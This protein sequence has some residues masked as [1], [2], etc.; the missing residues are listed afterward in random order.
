MLAS[1]VLSVVLLCLFSSLFSGL[2]A[3]QV[4]DPW[5]DWLSAD[6]AHFRVHYRTEHRAQAERATRAAERAYPRITEALKWAPRGRTEIVLFNEYDLPNGYATPLPYNVI[7]VFLAPADDGQLLDNSNWMDLLLTHEFTHTVH[8]DKVRGAP[9][10]LQTIF[11]RVPWFF[12]NVFQPAWALEGLAVYNESDPATGRGRLR[13]P[14]FEALLRAQAPRGFPSL[15]ELNADGRSLPVSKVYLYGAYFYDFLGRRYGPDAIF[16]YVEQYSGN[17]VPRLH[18]NPYDI[19]GKTLDLLWDE[20]LVDLN[21]RVAERSEA[22]R[23]QPEAA[24]Q[25]LVGPLFDIG[26]VAPLG[27]GAALAV[28]DDGLGATQLVRVNADGSQKVVAHVH[29]GTHIDVAPNGRVLLAQADVCN[30]RYL[31]YDLYRLEADN[32]IQQLTTCARLRRAVQAGD[33]IA[34]LQHDAG[35]TRLLLLDSAGREQR[36]LLPAVEDTDLIDVAASPDGKRISVVSKRE[37][38]WQVREIDLERPDAPAR[39]LFTHNAPVHGLRHGP[40]GLEFIAVSDGVYNVWRLDGAT[41]VR[42]THSH[43]GVVAQSGTQADGSLMLSVIAADGYEL[44]RM[45]GATTLQRVAVRATTAAATPTRTSAAEPSSAAAT[46]GANA[47]GLSEGKTYSALSALYP[48]SWLPAITSDRGL[49]AFGASTFGA[50]ALGW[51]QYAATAQWETSQRELL[52]SLEYLFVGQHHLAL[53]RN[54]SAKAWATNDGSDRTTLFERHT[55]AQWLSALPLIKRDRSLIFG[56]GAALDRIDSV[57]VDSATTTRPRDERLAAALVQFDTSGSNW[58]SEGSNRGQRSTLLY[59]TYK[60]F[61]RSGGTGY[62]GDVVRLDLRAFVPL[63]RSVFA[64]RHTEARARGRTEPFQLGGAVDAQLQL[65]LVLNER[66]I[67]LRGYRGDEAV[68]R[69]TDA[70]VTTLEWRTPLADVD[71]HAMSPPLGLNRLSAAVFFDI[72]GAWTAGTGPAHYQR[73]VGVE[74]LGEVKLLY[75]LGLQLRGGVARGLDD[76]SGTRAYLSLGRM[77]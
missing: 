31:V 36:V 57:Q 42:L 32:S 77:F 70:R 41:L 55:R 74:L 34:A 11:G 68:L 25:R 65:G 1:R 33:S 60:P 66:E 67:A 62:D 15:A 17:I 3:A 27:G 75:T 29:A 38:D 35:R 28:L 14:L 40:A 61:A 9:K 5:K 52:G 6:S 46:A 7:G 12:P 21:Q 53:Q 26:A 49:Q 48:R 4:A 45:T 58:W 13:G 50:D 44:R 16:K 24:G 10:V 43:T 18:T 37:G 2:A 39:V 22:L 8:L 20:F 23:R 19:T 51:H 63:G 69:G 54:L 71:R 30:G 47:S 56:V 76:P 59:E 73:G 64:L 72:G